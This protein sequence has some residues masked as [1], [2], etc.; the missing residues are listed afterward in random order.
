MMRQLCTCTSKVD[1]TYRITSVP[2]GLPR[3]TPTDRAHTPGCAVSRNWLA[4]DYCTV[5]TYEYGD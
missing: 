1:Y 2:W 4:W 3:G 5:Y